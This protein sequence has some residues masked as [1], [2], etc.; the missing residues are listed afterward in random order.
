MIS[1]IPW[2]VKNFISEHWP[3]AYHL[4]ANRFRDSNSGEHWDVTLERTWNAPNREWPVKVAAIAEHLEPAMSIV[5]VGCGNGSILRALRALGY[6][7]L[8]G[9]ELSEYAVARLNAEGINVARGSLLDIPFPSDRFHVAIASEVLEHVIRRRR[10]LAELTRIVRP[11]GI[12]MIFV[13]NDYLG[14]I[15]E[16]EHVIKYNAVSLRKF[17]SGFLMVKSITAMIEP[18]T[19]ARSLFA[20]CC[21][22]HTKAPSR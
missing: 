22:G 1:L 16:P 3:L 17:L 14:P 10:F 6:S 21:K 13:P 4:V 20:L 18:H 2:R 19:G 8:H 11:G 9:L 15:S 7:D 5:D 12:V